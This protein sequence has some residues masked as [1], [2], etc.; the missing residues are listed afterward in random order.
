MFNAMKRALLDIDVQ[1]QN[2]ENAKIQGKQIDQSLNG[3]K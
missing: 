1:R 3:R 2:E